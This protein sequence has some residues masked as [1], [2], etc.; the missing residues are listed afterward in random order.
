M[1]DEVKSLAPTFEGQA[2]NAGEIHLNILPHHSTIINECV[3]IQSEANMVADA[4]TNLGHNFIQLVLRFLICVN[5]C[6][7]LRNIGIPR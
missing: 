2:I 7:D 3:R 1:A 5:I 6:F 4:L